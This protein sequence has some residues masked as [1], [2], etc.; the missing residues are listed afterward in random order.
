MLIRRLLQQAALATQHLD[1]RP[2]TIGED[3]QP[4]EFR[5]GLRREMTT[6]I[7]LNRPISEPKRMRKM[8]VERKKANQL[9]TGTPRQNA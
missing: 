8:S 4:L 2:I 3:K 9:H 6:V 5:P 7:H 1:D